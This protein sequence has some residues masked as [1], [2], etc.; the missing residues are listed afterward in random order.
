MT[1]HSLDQAIKSMRTET[2]LRAHTVRIRE[3]VGRVGKW[4]TQFPEAARRVRTVTAYHDVTEVVK[5]AQP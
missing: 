3:F 4:E 1:R 5:Q 2:D